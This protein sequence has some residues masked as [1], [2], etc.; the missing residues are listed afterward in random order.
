MQ[1]HDIAHFPPESLAIVES[2][3]PKKIRPLALRQ[4]YSQYTGE[5]EY[6]WLPLS[7]LQPDEQGR[8]EV[9]ATGVVSLVSARVSVHCPAYK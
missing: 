4:E 7:L 3:M 9:T 1:R 8:L 6:L 2:N 5:K